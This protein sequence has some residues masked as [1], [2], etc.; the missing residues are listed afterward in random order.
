MLR[1]RFLKTLA[2]LTGTLVGP[3]AAW[4]NPPQ[5]QILLQI[6]PIAGFQYHDG[7]S[8]WGQLRK[9]HQLNLIRESNNAYDT[10][11]VRIDWKN[12]KLGYIPRA[13]NYAVAQLLDRGKKLAA[14][15][16]ELNDNGEP[17][18][19]AWERVKFEVLLIP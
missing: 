7:Q 16:V 5:R 9:G 14:Q 11:A 8:V 4:A 1:R 10:Y 3:V 19:W 2:A 15:I 17:W 13:E 12:C 6:S 18:E